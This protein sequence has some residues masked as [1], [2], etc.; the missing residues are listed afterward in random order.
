MDITDHQDLKPQDLTITAAPIP[1][2]PH[3]QDYVKRLLEKIEPQQIKK[4]IDMLTSFHT[5]FYTT[6]DGFEA[7]RTIY[8][9]FKEIAAASRRSDIEIGLFEHNWK[10]P[11][12]F[13]RIRGREL[14]DEIVILSSHE[15]SISNS[16]SGR[17][18]GADDNASGTASVLEIFRVL[19]LS[20]FKPSRTIE[21]HTYSAEEVG[22]RGSQDVASLYQSNNKT[23]HGVLH[24]DMTMFQRDPN[25]LVLIID[26][27]SIELTSFVSKL[28]SAYTNRTPAYSICGYGCSD[29][30][31]W[32]K[33]GYRS[34][35]PS[36]ASFGQKNP[37]IHT[38]NDLF[39]H[40]SL[41]QGMYF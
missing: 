26:Y 7:A 36:E 15:D 33:A 41:E 8:R 34:A 24:L 29:H 4:Y 6:D 10:Q 3:H 23:V 14:A 19:A 30:A 28:V 25:N 21:F 20:G 39:D 17:A 13:A 18:P 16:S 12:I 40:L 9:T 22:L 11:S 38:D 37:Y 35:Y 32:T 2:A 27:V 1:D 31:S 5:R